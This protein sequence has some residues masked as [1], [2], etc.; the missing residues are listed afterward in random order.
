MKRC[1]LPNRCLLNMLVL[2]SWFQSISFYLK[3]PLRH[4]LWLYPPTSVP[5]NQPQHPTKG[6]SSSYASCR[7]LP[8]AVGGPGPDRPVLRCC[9]TWVIGVWRDQVTSWWVQPICRTKYQSK[10]EIFPKQKWIENEQI[11]EI[12]ELVGAN[13]PHLVA[14]LLAIW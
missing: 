13:H 14:H 9:P 5:M 10:M 11:F 2:V 4:S 12:R 7:H 1:L 3:R 8:R 6:T